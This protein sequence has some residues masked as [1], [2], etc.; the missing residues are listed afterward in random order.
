MVN[1]FSSLS[2]IYYSR[3]SVDIGGKKVNYSNVSL[4]TFNIIIHYT[5]IFINR[6]VHVKLDKNIII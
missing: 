4:L 3:L 5:Y 2:I 1:N 6:I